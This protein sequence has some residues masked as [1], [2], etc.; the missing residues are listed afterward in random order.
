MAFGE[1]SPKWQSPIKRP[2]RAS[3]GNRTAGVWIVGCAFAVI[4]VLL[5]M[6]GCPVLRAI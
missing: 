3:P 1:F 6:N 2:R 5:F 4:L